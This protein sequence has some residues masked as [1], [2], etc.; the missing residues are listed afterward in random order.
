MSMMPAGKKQR[1]CGK[2]VISV[3]PHPGRPR[4]ALLRVGS[5]VL[6]AAIGEGGMSIFKREGDG[7]TPIADL[8]VVSGFRASPLRRPLR[9][10]TPLRPVI[11]ADG[12][13]DA[14]DHGAYNRPVRLPFAASH[15]T[16]AR[17]D[18]L[19][20]AVLVLDWNIRRRGRGLGSAIFAH[21]ARADYGP[22]K[23][24]IALS[25]RDLER[26]LPHIRPGTV[27]RVRR[28]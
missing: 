4:R 23:G 25:A 21:V 2:T 7:A 22:T 19:Y 20:D 13:C 17:A 9:S 10:A 27:F 6:P 28:N 14:P 8:A 1:R 3:R 18:H 5:L 11:A 26:L 15:E 24:C 12:W 16:L